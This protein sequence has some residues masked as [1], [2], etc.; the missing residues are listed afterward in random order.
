MKAI[1]L[2][3][4]F[5][6][7][8]EPEEGGDDLWVLLFHEVLYDAPKPVNFAGWFIDQAQIGKWMRR[9]SL[10]AK[11]DRTRPLTWPKMR[12]TRRDAQSPWTVTIQGHPPVTGSLGLPD[13]MA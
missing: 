11:A 9:A 1:H 3:Y 5:F 12:V 6:V 8:S 13:F 7:E 4:R 2:E 10:S